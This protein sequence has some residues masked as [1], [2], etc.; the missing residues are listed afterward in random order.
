MRSHTRKNKTWNVP[1]G[2]VKWVAVAT[3]RHRTME[4]A[5]PCCRLRAANRCSVQLVSPRSKTEKVRR[6][7]SR[8]TVAHSG[9]YVVLGSLGTYTPICMFVVYVRPQRS[10][11]SWRRNGS[12]FEIKYSFDAM[13]VPYIRSFGFDFIFIVNIFTKSEVIEKADNGPNLSKCMPILY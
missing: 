8:Q 3:H 5:P 12:S 9:L 1:S 10:S 7:I 2:Q 6:Q 13:I 4:C 11:L